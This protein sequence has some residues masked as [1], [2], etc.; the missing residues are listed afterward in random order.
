MVSVDASMDDAKR[1][2]H[3]AVTRQSKS[4]L[5]N[6]ALVSVI[7][8]YYP[9]VGQRYDLCR[10]SSIKPACQC[11]TPFFEGMAMKLCNVIWKV[12]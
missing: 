10:R 11:V 4:S 7:G 1:H 12:K 2:H 5:F 9:R 3:L 6:S 8:Q